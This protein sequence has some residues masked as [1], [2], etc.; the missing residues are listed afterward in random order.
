[1]VEKHV[2]ALGG[3]NET[4]SLVLNQLL[5]RTHRHLPAPFLTLKRRKN[6]RR[7]SVCAN[8]LPS[9]AGVCRPGCLVHSRVEQD[10]STLSKGAPTTGRGPPVTLLSRITKIE[11]ESPH[12]VAT[13]RG[14][15]P[16]SVGKRFR[17]SKSAIWP[18]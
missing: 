3:L 1:M 2:V 12:E 6:L 5:N 14:R 15:S 10:T 16:I 11:R 9:A 7:H 18:G 17:V 8:R 13:V 4:K